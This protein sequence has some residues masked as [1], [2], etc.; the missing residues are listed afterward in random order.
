M[1]TLK[2]IISEKLN[3][4]ET[5]PAGFES[6]VYKTQKKIFEQTLKLLDE[7]SLNADGTIKLTNGNLALIEK[8]GD[9]LKKTIDGSGYLKD[10]AAFVKQFDKQKTLNTSFFKKAF[11]DFDNKAVYDTVYSQAKTYAIDLLSDNAVMQNVATFKEIL[12]NAISSSDTFTNLIKNIQG[13]IMGNSQGEGTLYRYAKQ[14]AGDL[15]AIADRQYTQ[16]IANDFKLVF[17]EY[18]G[19]LID[20]SRKFC[21]DRHRK[22]YHKKEIEEMASLTWQGKMKNTTEKT[23]FVVCGGYN[24]KHS[25]IPVGWRSVP[26]AVIKRNLEIGNITKEDVPKAEWKRAGIAA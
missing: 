11:G 7:L 5:A 24:C 19:A 16:V 6:S 14:N 1:P 20:D 2:E 23:I 21:I 9:N 10:V 17:Y 22:I 15:F 3:A 25:W 26:A 18:A 13:N 4:L 8:I 12:N